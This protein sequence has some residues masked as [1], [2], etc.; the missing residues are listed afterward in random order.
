MTYVDYAERASE[1]RKMVK[2]CY[3]R[4]R[5]AAKDAAREYD[6]ARQYARNAEFFAHF[7][8]TYDTDGHPTAATFESLV[9]TT[10]SLADTFLN[11]SFASFER[12]REYAQLARD[13]D[14]LEAQR[15]ARL[16]SY[17]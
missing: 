3:Y 15:N 16:A 14:A 11:S 13:Y 8:P 7:R 5:K 6:Y 17:G 2:Q 9:R 1:C 4:S 12:A 10:L